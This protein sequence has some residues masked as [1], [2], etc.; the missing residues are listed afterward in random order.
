MI[1]EKIRRLAVN[2]YRHFDADYARDVPAEGY[3][4]WRKAEIE[5]DLARRQ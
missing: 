2:Y 3:G 1:T 4:G 5:I